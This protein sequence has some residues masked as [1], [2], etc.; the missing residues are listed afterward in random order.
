MLVIWL[1]STPFIE[2]TE[3]DIDVVS[4][5]ESNQRHISFEQNILE[6]FEEIEWNYWR[7]IISEEEDTIVIT[8]EYTVSETTLDI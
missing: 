4:F 8:Y 2:I 3:E 1:F 5:H 6:P 7:T